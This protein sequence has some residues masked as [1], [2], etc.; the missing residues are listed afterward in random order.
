M[1]SDYNDQIWP[2]LI[3]R[4]VGWA[5]LW[6]VRWS[7]FSTELSLTGGHWSIGVF[8]I[9]L[10]TGQS[11]IVYFIRLSHNSLSLI[12]QSTQKFTLFL[13]NGQWPVFFFFRNNVYIGSPTVVTERS[14]VE[15]LLEQW[16]VEQTGH[17]IIWQKQPGPYYC[18]V[19]DICLTPPSFADLIWI[20]LKWPCFMIFSAEK[21]A[22]SE[23][24][25][26]VVKS[27]KV[28]GRSGQ[29]LDKGWFVSS[30]PISYYHFSFSRW[31]WKVFGSLL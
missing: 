7:N 23:K 10:T 13:K 28:C 17:D 21:G 31:W 20:I 9:K 30:S 16:L 1:I 22:Q 25:R 3:R 14:L 29:L 6:N 2:V 5:A 26:K 18:P 4:L 15:G 24:V 12:F 27:E 8:D 19:Y 11:R